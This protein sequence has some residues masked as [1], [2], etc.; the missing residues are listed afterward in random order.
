MIILEIIL[1]LLIMTLYLVD[2]K[3][4][5]VHLTR[6][7][8]TSQSSSMRS[9]KNLAYRRSQSL[10]LTR[11]LIFVLGFSWLYLLMSQMNYLLSFAIFLVGYMVLRISTRVK[12]FEPILSTIMKLMDKVVQR[13]DKYLSKLSRNL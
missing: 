11:S 1:F 2:H 12:L 7:Q 10:L 8:N 13:Y 4:S 9:L 6:L 3:I 5:T